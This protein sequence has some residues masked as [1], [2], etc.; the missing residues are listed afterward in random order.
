MNATTMPEQP[1]RNAAKKFK[2]GVLILGYACLVT[3]LA[4]LS[5]DKALSTSQEMG[6]YQIEETRIFQGEQKAKELEEFMQERTGQLI[7]PP[8]APEAGESEQQ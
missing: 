8:V 1:S 5:I 2:I 3:G 6:R 7:D 4:Y